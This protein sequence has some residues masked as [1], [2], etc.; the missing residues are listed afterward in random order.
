MLAVSFGEALWLIIVSFLF[1]AYLMMLFSVIIDL[2]RDREIGGVAKAI[3]AILLIFFPLVTMLIYLIV[4]GR[5]MAERSIQQATQDKAA[6]DSYVREVATVDPA[7]SL[8]TASQ[9]HEEGKITAEEYT[10]LKAKILS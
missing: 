10:A 5:G 8:A 4:R 9:L 2:F 6:F 7:T 1:I 3:W